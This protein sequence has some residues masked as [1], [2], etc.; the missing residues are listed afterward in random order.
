MSF[1]I[2]KLP[3][4]NYKAIFC[5]GKTIRLALDPTKDISELKYPEFYDVDIFETNNGICH[6]GCSFCYLNGNKNGKYVKN[7]SKVINEFF[8]PMDENERPFQVALPGSG[9]FFEHPEWEE[10]L[11]TFKSLG[12]MPNYTTNGMWSSRRTEECEDIINKTIEYC[13]GVAVSCHKHIRSQWELAAKMY[14][15]AGIKLNFHII[16]SDRESVD[17]FIEIYEKWKDRVD[18]F[19]LLPLGKQG[20]AKDSDKEVD[21][22]YLVEKSPEDTGKLAFGAN[23]YPYLTKPGHNFNVSLYEPES[24]SGFLSLSDKKVYKSSFNLEEK[25]YGMSNA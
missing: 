8:G 22:E 24:M 1:K 13:G 19:V 23:F 21:W 25:S 11:S 17:Y 14:A 10:I 5:N 4:S 16:I 18:Y 12:I 15:K 20:R 9:E 7:A 6:A 2:R 3:E